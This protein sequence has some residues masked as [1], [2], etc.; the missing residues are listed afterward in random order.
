M[1]LPKSEEQRKGSGMKTADQIVSGIGA[2][3]QRFGGLLRCT[4]CGREEPLGNVG[5]KLGNG[6]PKCH[7][8]TMRWLTQREL[9]EEA[10]GGR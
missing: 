7:G 9:D 4:V 10:Q 6:W 8:Y 1:A 2:D 3:L 5:H